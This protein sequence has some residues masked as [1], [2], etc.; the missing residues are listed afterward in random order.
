MSPH[1]KPSFKWIMSFVRPPEV[2]RFSSPKFVF[3]LLIILLSLFSCFAWSIRL[4]REWG[5]DFGVYYSGAYY[6]N[7]QYGL[8]SNFF[9]HKGPLIYVLLKALGSLIGWGPLQATT[10]L[11]VISL[12]YVSSILLICIAS[13]ASRLVSSYVLLACLLSLFLQDSNASIACLQLA[14]L[15]YSLAFILYA[16]PPSRAGAPFVF[17][18]LSALFFAASILCRIDSLVFLPSLLLAFFARNASKSSLKQNLLAAGIYLLS[19]ATFCCLI[20]IS[21]SKTLFYTL[22]DFLESNIIFNSWYK[23]NVYSVS[24]YNYLF[25]RGLLSDLL[26][27]TLAVPLLFLSFYTFLKI[28]SYL[29]SPSRGIVDGSFFQYMIG[30]L[31]FVSGV[32]MFMYSGSDKNYHR[33]LVIS[34]SLVWTAIAFD[35]MP[36]RLIK[37]LTS[38]SLAL[39]V[40]VS[41]LSYYKSHDYI[42][43]LNQNSFTEFDVN[44]ILKGGDVIDLMRQTSL[45]KGQGDMHVVGGRGWIYL[46]GGVAPPRSVNDWWLY[47]PTVTGQYYHNSHLMASHNQL[48]SLPKGRTYIID[49]DLLDIK[50]DMRNPLLREL[51]S[52]SIIRKRFH[53]YSLMAIR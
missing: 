16:K 23:N 40:F 46:F 3:R 29:K 35:V 6:I 33:L 21:C 26:K 43:A 31:F 27:T 28:K 1:I 5:S 32:I 38:V 52:K 50:E 14:L 18:V 20:Y 34:P 10:S 9:D 36:T 24:L 13:N 49:N 12:F 4:A 17:S 48:L 47:W 53:D 45:K 19:V 22:G 39:L 7:E 2:V 37:I 42:N 8:Y 25:R 30:L 15:N 41:S 11:F 51:T 44:S